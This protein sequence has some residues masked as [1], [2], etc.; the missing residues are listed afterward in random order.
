MLL[1]GAGALCLAMPGF[2]S[3]MQTGTVYSLTPIYKVGQELKYKTAMT[4]DGQMAMQMAFNIDEKTTKVYP[5]GSA[6]MSINLI[7][8]TMTMNGQTMSPP[9][10]PEMTVHVSKY[11]ATSGAAAK[12]NMAGNIGA[13]INEGLGKGISVGQSVKI[14]NTDPKSKTHVYGTVTCDGVKDGLINISEDLKIQLKGNSG[15]PMHVVGTESVD[16][17]THVLQHVKSTMTHVQGPQG[18]T[19]SKITTTMDIVK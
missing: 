17:V 3:P 4:M 1:Y 2:A 12:I 19:F 7:G 18:M 13:M 5:D 6:D 16:Q 15:T 9:A 10:P 8:M 11:G 14:D